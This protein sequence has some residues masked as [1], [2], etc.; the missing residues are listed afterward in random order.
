MKHYFLIFVILFCL[1]SIPAYST[2]PVVYRAQVVTIIDGDTVRVVRDGHMMTLR[3]YGIDCPEIRQ[4]YGTEA[5]KKIKNLIWGKTVTVTELSADRYH[6]RIVRIQIGT[7]QDV[8][9][10]MLRAGLAWWYQRYAPHDVIYQTLEIHARDA[11]R[12]LWQERNPIPPW[13]WRK[14]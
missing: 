4:P 1:L 9:E 8:G 10:E 5:K 12:G 6:R 11:G 7:G 13:K 14:Q 2:E 3:L